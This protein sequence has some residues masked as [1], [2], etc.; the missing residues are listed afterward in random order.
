MAKFSIVNIGK[1][2]KFKREINSKLSPL[3]VGVNPVLVSI[4]VGGLDK[5]EKKSRVEP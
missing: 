4:Q 1:I 3:W 2:P 5:R